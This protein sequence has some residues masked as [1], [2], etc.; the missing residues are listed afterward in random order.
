MSGFLSRVVTICLSI[1]AASREHATVGQDAASY[2]M[3]GD[4]EVT[5]QTHPNVVKVIEA[6]NITT[7]VFPDN[8]I[9]VSL[10]RLV[11]CA[12]MLRYAMT[13]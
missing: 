8:T 13:R 3:I 5:P 7:T 10:C 4:E 1:P 9:M 2:V 6:S 12:T 11:V